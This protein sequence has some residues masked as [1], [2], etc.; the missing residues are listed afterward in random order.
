M[1]V[2][3]EHAVTHLGVGPQHLLQLSFDN[4]PARVFH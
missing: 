4:D 3:L 2:A 1:D